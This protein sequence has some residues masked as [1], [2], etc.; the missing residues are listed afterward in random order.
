[1]RPGVTLSASQQAQINAQAG[2]P[3]ADRQIDEVFATYVVKAPAQD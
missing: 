3:V 1:M 2:K